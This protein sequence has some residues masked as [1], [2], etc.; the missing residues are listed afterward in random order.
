[1]LEEALPYSRGALVRLTHNNKYYGHSHLW[2]REMT[3][4]SIDKLAPLTSKEC[5]L[6][7][8]IGP[9]SSDEERYAVHSTP[10][11]LAWGV[12]LKVGDTVLARLPGKEARYVKAIIKSLGVEENFRRSLFGLE[13]Q[14][15]ELLP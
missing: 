12:G 3:H 14:V 7:D 1:M 8:A 4:V 15:G 6:L 11:R 13:I 9:G 5:A 2:V 10:G